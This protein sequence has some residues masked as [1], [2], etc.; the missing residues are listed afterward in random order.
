[1]RK[2]L[3]VLTCLALSLSAYCRPPMYEWETHLSYSDVNSIALSSNKVYGLSND[4]L[5]SVDRSDGEIE[6]YSK[7]N[8][9]TGSSISKIGYD[10]DQR[11]LLIV[12]QNGQIDILHDNG[13]VSSIIDLY[14]KQLS[15]TNK[16]PNAIV[17]NDGYAYLA[18]H[19]GII[20]INM[21]KKE[22]ADTYYIGSEGTEIDVLS[23]TFFADSIYAISSE[24]IYS[25]SLKDKNL[26]DFRSWQFTRLTD[27]GTLRQIE[28][29]DSVKYVLT[30]EG[31]Y[32]NIEQKWQRVEELKSE[33]YSIKKYNGH[34][35]ASCD[36]GIRIIY[37]DFHIGYDPSFWPAYEAYY[38]GWNYWIAAG[39]LGI[40]YIGS[41]GTHTN[42]CPNGPAL[43]IPYR[44]KIEND[45]LYVVPGGRWSSQYNRPG[46]VMMY[47]GTEW[48]NI[49]Q[50]QVQSATGK[51]ALDFMNVAV[52]PFNSEH[53]FVTSYGTGVYEFQDNKL[54]NHNTHKNSIIK[55]IS[56]DDSDYYTRTDGALYDREGNL[57]LIN[58]NEVPYSIIM[59]TRDGRWLVQNIYINGRRVVI[60]TPGEMFIDNNNYNYKWIPYC[61]YETG[62]ILWD[63]RGTYDFFQDDIFVQRTSFTDQNGNVLRPESLPCVAQ[64]KDG[65]LWLGT[66]LGP[67]LIP[68]SVDFKTSDACKRVLLDR[69]DGTN[70]ADYLLD[71]VQINAIAIDGANRKW[72]GTATSGLY[73]LSDDGKETI[74]HFTM[75]N[76]PLISN[77]ILSL[78]INQ[79][80]GEVFVGTAAGLMSYQSDA[81]SSSDDLKDIFAY[82]NPVRETDNG[83]VT[84]TGLQDKSVVKI[85]DAAGR[86]VY[87]TYSE[88]GTATW[89]TNNS[90]GTRVPS[91]VY[92]VMVSSE[93]GNIH[94]TTK[95]LIMN[96][97]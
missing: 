34:L 62:L 54:I 82:P 49:T 52:D 35:I 59:Y 19:F 97:K 10:E 38:D 70:L 5:F 36:D 65:T 83:V 68:A 7:L 44:M 77:E 86:L 96:R 17:F 63:N 12:Y 6:Y 88:G 30:S 67:I 25:S 58:A 33:I 14:N 8:G 51:A 42:Y 31:L 4:A 94:G 75:N 18:M 24:G 55:C 66:D 20:V 23:I 53:I 22:I 13:N 91:G 89:D 26:L 87:E 48:T 64:D 32:R 1:M 72:I 78:A 61:R 41:D 69:N 81:T 73:L 39:V 2:L 56:E 93:D 95:V 43:N 27:Y 45:K 74:E 47:D 15:G 76:S 46:M 71:G 80:T 84:I 21:N 9:L 85:V 29:Y 57:Y 90:R 3:L 92:V 11:S 40:G 16:T 60:H 79:K 37:P 28:I 50:D